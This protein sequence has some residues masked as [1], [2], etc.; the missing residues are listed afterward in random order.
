MRDN[1]TNY[2]HTCAVHQYI[3]ILQRNC[4]NH[5]HVRDFGLLG[6]PQI[7]SLSLLKNFQQCAI[8]Q[9]IGLAST[10]ST[11]N[12]N[13][14]NCG[15]SGSCQ[16]PHGHASCGRSTFVCICKAPQI[17]AAACYTALQ[18]ELLQQEMLQQEMLQE[19][20]AS[21]EEMHVSNS[22]SIKCIWC[23]C[24]MTF[25]HQRKHLR[26]LHILIVCTAC[27]FQQYKHELHLQI[28]TNGCLFPCSLS[29]M[30][31]VELAFVKDSMLRGGG[32]LTWVGCSCRCHVAHGD[33]AKSGAKHWS[34]SRWQ[35]LKQGCSTSFG[36]TV[37]R[38]CEISTTADPSVTLVIVTLVTAL[39]LA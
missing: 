29:P 28:G 16:S 17:L 3:K 33:T 35:C 7:L 36:C 37:V 12:A 32:R 23:V 6:R 21:C 24:L 9:H 30:A 2:V 27:Y 10:F 5:S 13:D 19:I 34:V 20:A 14:C 22:W 39:I 1:T 11:S 26:Q 18:Q 38:A 31:L 4:F 25:M 8:L 15:Q